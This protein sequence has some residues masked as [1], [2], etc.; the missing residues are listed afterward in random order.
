MD[1]QKKTGMQPDT[2]NSGSN[3]HNLE[4]ITANEFGTEILLRKIAIRE[5]Y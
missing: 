3:Q 1:I 2:I 4:I 5:K